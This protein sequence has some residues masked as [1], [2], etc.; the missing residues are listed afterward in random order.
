MRRRGEANR[1]EAGV[2]KGSRGR[3]VAGREKKSEKQIKKGQ[4]TSTEEKQ[5]RR[6]KKV[7]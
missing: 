5:T 1:E 6:R 7:F 4:L 2:G 3:R